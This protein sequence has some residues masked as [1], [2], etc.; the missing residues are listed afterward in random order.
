MNLWHREGSS[1]EKLN[2]AFESQKLSYSD[3][4]VDL[5]NSGVN[6]ILSYAASRGHNIYHF[7]MDDLAVEE[8]VSVGYMNL[9]E[10]DESWDGDPLSAYLFLRDRGKRKIPLSDIQLFVVRGDDIRDAETPNLDILRSAE[11]HSK[12][13]ESVDATLSTTDK[14]ETIQRAPQLP[15]P[16]TFK[17]DTLEEAKEAI[18]KLPGNS[19]YF[20]LKDRYGYGCGAQVH[21]L[22]FD[23]KNLDEK[24][25]HFLEEYKHI[26]IQEFC[27][28]VSEGD[29]IV[30]FFDDELIGAMKR[31]AG[32]GEW[33]TNASLGANEVYYQLTP[34][35]EQIART[36]KRSFPECR[37]ASVD[38]LPSGKILEI[39]AFPGGSGLLKTH[40]VILGKMVMDRLEGELLGPDYAFTHSKYNSRT[41]DIHSLYSGRDQTRID[42]IDV[43]SNERHNLAL[44][45]IIQIK[46]KSNDFILSLPHSGFFIPEKYADH[47]SISEDMLVEV[48]LFSD[49]IYQEC[50]G[51]HVISR[52]APFFIDMNRE[53]KGAPG[54]DIPHHLQNPP[55]EYY[56]VKD[57]LILKEKYTDKDAE[58]IL[59]YYDLYHDILNRLIDFM[60]KDKGYA[61]LIDGHSMTKKS[62]GRVHDSGKTRDDFVVGTLWDK[63]ADDRI[64]NTFVETLKNEADLH[65]LGLTVSKNVPYSGGYITRKHHKPEDNV[66][67]IQLEVSMSSY[68]YEANDPD[69]PRRY[70]IKSH[71]LNTIQEVIKKTLEKTAERA[72]DIYGR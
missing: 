7:S 69:I 43:Y 13:L 60:K 3:K 66:H 23:D 50:D 55:H 65:D 2:I 63:S 5:Y 22:R 71:R 27:P 32:A 14:Y 68:M 36:L 38:M 47:F 39:N 52:F 53:R 17:A 61:L 56:T 28:E 35:Q 26:L 10:L 54:S 51:I 16:L 18:E 31:T 11:K 41:P 48:D 64:I 62:L 20:V 49:L 67:V 72:S 33:K 59:Q 30:T 24:L 15:H 45:E 12:L 25:T 9:L 4:H 21:Q 1:S 46:N 6:Q 40:G 42:V 19:G 58:D 8:G 70:S 34:E 57:E 29:I 44:D 37:L